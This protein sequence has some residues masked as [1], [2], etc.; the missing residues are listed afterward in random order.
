MNMEEPEEVSQFID[1]TTLEKHERWL[2]IGQWMYKEE[3]YTLVLPPQNV[4]R[5]IRNEIGSATGN[6]MHKDM[7]SDNEISSTSQACEREDTS[8][9]GRMFP[10]LGSISTSL[11]TL[12]SQTETR[13]H[14]IEGKMDAVDA[15]VNLLEHG[16]RLLMN[17]EQW[18]S[19]GAYERAKGK[20]PMIDPM[21]DDTD[22]QI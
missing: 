21:E 7:G 15:R 14:T 12:A 22:E 17:E 10:M 1:D 19:Y 3:Y 5:Q 18:P 9:E 4:S 16:M 11:D 2:R 6:P 13:L 8:M 20:K